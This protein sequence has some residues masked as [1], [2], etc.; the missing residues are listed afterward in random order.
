MPLDYR[1]PQEGFYHLPLV[2]GLF[3]T[4]PNTV[5]LR[6]L[7]QCISSWCFCEVLTIQQDCILDKLK[8]ILWCGTI[9]GLPEG[10]SPALGNA[11]VQRKAD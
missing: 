5:V 3:S 7:S 4:L 2:M 9:A 1:S 8:V 11:L 10:P 6:E